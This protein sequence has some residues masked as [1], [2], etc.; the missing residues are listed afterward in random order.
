MSLVW[1]QCCIKFLLPTVLLYAS[2]WLKHFVVGYHLEGRGVSPAQWQIWFWAR[3]NSV[4]RAN[5]LL[6]SSSQ[7]PVQHLQ[8]VAFGQLCVRGLVRKSRAQQW[9][10][11]ILS[12]ISTSIMTPSS[13]KTGLTE[14]LTWW[15]Q[16][17]NKSITT[18]ITTTTQDSSCLME[19]I[20]ASR[21]QQCVVSLAPWGMMSQHGWVLVLA[22]NQN[23]SWR[24][25]WRVLWGCVRGQRVVVPA[26][27]QNWEGW[28]HHSLAPQVS[29]EGIDT[30]TTVR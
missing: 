4:V 11:P 29:T 9:S 27:S 21:P 12:I 24:T 19:I 18:I 5:H 15:R 28:T 20:L 1:E 8:L 22:C 7:K 16:P 14:W 2:L 6:R 17:W 10:L 26:Q 13:S 25:L 23:K 30:T 3:W